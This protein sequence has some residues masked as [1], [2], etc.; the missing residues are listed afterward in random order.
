MSIES[1]YLSHPIRGYLDC[2]ETG[3][4]ATNVRK[5]LAVA[6]AIR[7]R[8]PWLSL[9]CPGEHQDF[10]SRAYH[11]GYLSDEKILDI[12]CKI[13]CARELVI[14]YDPDNKLSTGMQK[15]WEV[16]TVVNM[17]RVRVTRLSEEFFENLVAV[18]SN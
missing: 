14:F 18:T 6:N 5:A 13:M 8:L 16:A 2:Q 11:L 17:H 1:A 15:E 7:C 9:Y 3:I 12:D 4:K 10:V